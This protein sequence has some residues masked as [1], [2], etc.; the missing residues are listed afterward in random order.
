MRALLFVL[1]IPFIPLGILF[2]IA[3]LGAHV[4]MGMVAKL[5]GGES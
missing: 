1:A 5:L 3:L 2:G 4:G